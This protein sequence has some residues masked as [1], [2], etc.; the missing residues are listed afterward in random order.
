MFNE[1]NPGELFEVVADIFQEVSNHLN[2]VGFYVSLEELQGRYDDALKKII[3]NEENE[4]NC[5]Y[6]S[7]E[8]QISMIDKENYQC[9][10]ALYF[11]DLGESFHVLEAQTKKLDINCLTED[12]RGELKREGNIEF[13]IEKPKRNVSV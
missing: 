10:Y 8:F 2:R 7:G 5:R 9:S 4:K 13:E 3:L 1:K 12:F 6:I 11:E